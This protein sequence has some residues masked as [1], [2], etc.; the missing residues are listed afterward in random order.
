MDTL[1]HDRLRPER[2]EAILDRRDGP[3]GPV[4]GSAT[5]TGARWPEIEPDTPGDDSVDS[6]TGSRALDRRLHDEAPPSR[7]LVDVYLRQT[8]HTDLLSRGEEIALAKRI[9][10]AQEAVLTGLCQVPALVERIAR[11][12]QE[13][14][15]GQRRVVDLVDLYA[16]GEPPGER[17]LD[18]AQPSD[19]EAEGPAGREA[20]QARMIAPRLAQLATLA[21]EIGAL[22][23]KRGLALARG[24]DLGKSTRKRLQALMADFASETAALR[25]SPDRVSDLVDELERERQTL[26]GIAQPCGELPVGSA[27]MGLPVAEFRRAAA[28]IG[29]ARRE[30]HAAREQ[31]VRAH[32]RLVVWVAKKY[33]RAS[34]LDFLDLIQEGNLGL[35]H[36]IEKF[37]Y[38]RGVKVST[39]AVWWIRQSI[40]RAIA[41]QGRTIRIPVHISEVAAKVLQ[42]RRRL[43]QKEGRE[44]AAFE[45]AARSGIPLA[46]VEQILSIVQ[47]PTSLDAPVGEDGDATLGDLIEAKDAVDPQAVA[48]A[49]AL[50]GALAEALAELNPREQRILRMRFGIDGANDHTLAEIGEQL[51]VTRERIR[52][53]EAQALEKLRH[54][55]R[56][57]KLATFVDG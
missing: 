47:Q 32:L 2:E 28:D 50:K 4:E 15:T 8:G 20:E 17:K 23:R 41:D 1:T 31:M 30:L 29:R 45:I 25:L 5:A 40:A 16:S 55:R 12:G 6:E 53:I 49:S 54:A 57:R 24:R 13:V 26:R 9:E 34:S 56:A 37:N 14:A 44:P 27:P 19:A 38:R 51:G 35:M 10:A 48:E 33:R 36:A 39:Y 11:W 21:R 3:I 52:Q 7:D 18:E 22:T 42:A 46:R 43:S